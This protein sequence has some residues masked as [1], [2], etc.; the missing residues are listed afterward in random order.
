[1]ATNRKSRQNGKQAEQEKRKIVQLDA[2][3][4]ISLNAA[5]LDIGGAEIW[6]AV[7]EDRDPEPVRAFDTFTA[8]LHALANW[9]EACRIDTVAME[10]TGIY[11]IPIYQILEER[12]F[13][14]FLVNARHIKNVPGKKTDILD[15]Q[16]IQQLHTYGLLQASFVP[17]Q[18]MRAF[19]SLVRHREGLIRY[20][21]SHIQ[22]MQKA[23]HLMNIQLTN[24]ISDVT[25]VTGMKI[26]RSILAGNHD[27]QQLA[28]YRDGRCKKS[29]EEIA[30]SLE[31]DY[32]P[33]HLFAL[34]QAVELYDVYNEKIEACDQE[35]EARY[36]AFEPQVDL[37]E[38][39]LPPRKRNKQ[40][41]NAPNFEMRTYLYQIT[42]VDLTAIDGVDV[43]IIQDVLSEI[44]I[45]MSKWP[46]VK[47]FTSWLRICPY[48]DKSGGKVLRNKSLRTSSR[49][50][51]A[52]KRAA[53]NLRESDSALGNYFRRMRFRH[54]TPKAAAIAAHRLARIF[55]FMLKNKTEYVDIGSEE[56][57]ARY[58][59]RAL[60]RLKRQAH[61]L[62]VKVVAE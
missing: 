20:R 12:G 9:L 35:L 21:A 19:R 32:R 42:G 4:Q 22:H 47:H 60:R 13:E 6:V 30:K 18:A 26:I 17:D 27:P 8:D 51:N 14:L 11:W 54:G 59:E 29:V 36:A 39:P 55:Y 37:H 24:V 1:M 41:K 34:R 40:S 23:L 15:C 61:K 38:K 5:G 48:Q 10:S 52:L 3:K 57:E 45:D 44:G 46:T 31:G 49:A 28:Q 58:R 53:V 2:L 33:E 16:W 43:L 25:G 62:G 7:P 50:R 56:E